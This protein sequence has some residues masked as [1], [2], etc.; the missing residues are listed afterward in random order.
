MGNASSAVINKKDPN[1]WIMLGFICLYYF[2]ILGFTNQSFNIFLRTISTDLGWDAV[3]RA[4][5]VTAMSSGMIWFVFIAG[6]LMDKFSVKKVYGSA[7]VFAGVL[8]LLRSRTPAGAAESATFFFAVM[9][10]FGVA[11]A[12]YMPA[13]TKVIGIW[14]DHSE[15]AFANGCLTA[16][17]PL[18]QFTANLFAAKLMAAAGGWRLLYNFIGIGIVFIVIMFFLFGKER[19]SSEAALDSKILG[20]ADLGL[21]KNIKGIIKVPYVWIFIIANMCFLGGIYGGGA[22]SQYIVQSDP[23]W[24]ID[25]SVSGRIPAFNNFASMIAYVLVPLII[26]KI[27]NKYYTRVSI[28]CGFIAA[29]AFVFGYLSYSFAILCTC[30]AIAGVCYG[31]IVPAPKVLMLQLP[32]VSGSRAGTAMGVY[33]TVERLG[34]TLF[35]SV[36]GALLALKAIPGGQMLGIFYSIQFISPVMLIIGSVILKKKKKAAAAV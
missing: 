3:Q 34:I 27:G 8:I 10:L 28:I 26:R 19:K 22:Y 25:V 16:A 32:E 24:G 15:L 20:E 18:G 4:A 9:F 36:M 29:A 33:V 14:F 30:M 6:I 35:V 13:S 17:S 5:V 31:A 1:R 21:W 11:S 12:F 2:V 23:G 7:I